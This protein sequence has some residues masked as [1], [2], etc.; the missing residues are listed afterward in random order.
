MSEPQHRGYE[1]LELLPEPGGK[2]K[3]VVDGEIVERG[4]R[5]KDVPKKMAEVLKVYE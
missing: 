4:I 2:F 1:K 3:I 5:R